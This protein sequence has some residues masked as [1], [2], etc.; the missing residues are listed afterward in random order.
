MPGQLPVALSGQLGAGRYVDQ[1][2]DQVRVARSM[3][4]NIETYK[5]WYFLSNC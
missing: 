5:F 2:N 4:T 3:E 1:H